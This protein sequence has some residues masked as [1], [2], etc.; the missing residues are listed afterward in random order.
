MVKVIK[1]KKPYPSGKGLANNTFQLPVKPENTLEMTTFTVQ[2]LP[3]KELIFD[4]SDFI[5][6]KA[7]NFVN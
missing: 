2:L 1:I 3:F 7:S 4:L 5:L 6:Y